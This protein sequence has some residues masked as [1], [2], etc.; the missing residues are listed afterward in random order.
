MSTPLIE[1]RVP[2]EAASVSVV[3]TSVASLA[4]RLDFTLDRLEDLRLATNEA[5]ALLLGLAAGGPSLSATVESPLEG[6][7]R[8]ELRR[9]GSS[10][11]LP[12]DES[13]TWTVLSALVDEF[14]VDDSDGDV[15]LT[16]TA[17]NGT[18]SSE[19]RP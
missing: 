16:L 8:I 13:F 3:R 10:G 2:G 17:S 1:M 15:R 4:A 7:L 5:C 18:A 6:Q 19:A 12:G 11:D 9:Q 14:V